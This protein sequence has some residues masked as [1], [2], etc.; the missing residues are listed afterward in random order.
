[1]SQSPVAGLRVVTFNVLPPMYSI[2]SRWAAASGAKIV[3]VVTT[4]GPASR[5]MPMFREVAAMAGADKREVLITTRLRTVAAP[6]I[7]ALK[8]GDDGITEND[9][10]EAARMEVAALAQFKLVFETAALVDRIIKL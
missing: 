6:L 8:L 4:P 1:M 9:L 10:R 2:V 3:L 5:P 7:R